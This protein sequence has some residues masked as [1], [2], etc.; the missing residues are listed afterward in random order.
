MWLLESS[1]RKG[2][3]EAALLLPSRGALVKG[4][5]FAVSPGIDPASAINPVA[6]STAPASQLRTFSPLQ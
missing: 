4:A 5:G 3:R 6:L 1:I 2:A